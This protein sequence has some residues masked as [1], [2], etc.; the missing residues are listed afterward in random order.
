MSEIELLKR[1]L[2]RER[3]AKAKAEKLLEDKTRELFLANEELKNHYQQLEQTLSELKTTQSQLV[4]SSKLASIG[5]LAAG[6]AH[7]INN[8]IAFVAN[9]TTVLGKYIDKI[10]PILMQCKTLLEK[11]EHGEAVEE[12]ADT[13][14]TLIKK[15]NLDFILEDLES[16]ITDS[17]EGMNRVTDIVAGL[18]SFSRVDEFETQEIDIHECLESTIKVI[19]NELKYNCTLKK[20]FSD[21]PPLHCHPSQ[22]NQVFMNLIVNAGQAIEE[23]GTITIKTQHSQ[24]TIVIEISDTGNGIEPEHIDKLFD[25]FFTTKPVGTGTGLGLSISYG[26]VQDH[27]GRIEV[28]STVGVGTTFKISLPTTPLET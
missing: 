5:Q 3:K 18:K 19:W 22:L 9:N 4:Q 12:I 17:V 1:S 2:E 16:L 27:G 7:E 20:E 10:Q 25:P 13:I 24:Q 21:L 11:I 28:D 14:R 26:I 6:V 15:N 8:P 23:E